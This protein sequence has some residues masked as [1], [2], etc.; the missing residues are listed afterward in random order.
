VNFG[1]PR[2]PTGRAL[3][4][5]TALLLLVKLVVEFVLDSQRDFSVFEIIDK[6]G[7]WRDYRLRQRFVVL[8]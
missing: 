6:T 8:T 4:L 1:E 3:P 5:Q 7:F 2:S